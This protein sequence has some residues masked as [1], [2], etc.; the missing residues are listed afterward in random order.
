MK[1]DGWLGAEL[2]LAVEA[3]FVVVVLERVEAGE[4]RLQHDLR[5]VCHGHNKI[6]QM[7]MNSFLVRF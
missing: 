6:G 2:A 4:P 5:L 7:N 1:R 3:V